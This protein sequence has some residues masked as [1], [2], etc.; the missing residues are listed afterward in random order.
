M[1]CASSTEGGPSVMKQ[2]GL[3]GSPG[4]AAALAKGLNSRV[5]TAT[6]VLTQ[7][8]AAADA[9]RTGKSNELSGKVQAQ[10]GLLAG[11]TRI[12]FRT[13]GASAKGASASTSCTANFGDNAPPAKDG[14]VVLALGT[15][16][17]GSSGYFALVEPETKTG[18]LLGGLLPGFGTEADKQ[19][20]FTVS[21]ADPTACRADALALLKAAQRDMLSLAK[22]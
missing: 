20:I 2:A 19:F 8:S 5:V 21:V 6:Y 12:A 17:A 18:S 13:P 4:L 3:Y 1:T 22:P 10:L 14:D 15:A 11:Q 7:G 16:L 9:T